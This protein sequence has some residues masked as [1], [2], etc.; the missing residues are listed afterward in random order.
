MSPR[1]ER[2]DLKSTFIH[3]RTYETFDMK[4]CYLDWHDE[5]NSVSSEI[6]V[7]QDCRV[8]DP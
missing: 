4:T 5:F 3:F 1:E 2:K 7:S 8:L 6:I